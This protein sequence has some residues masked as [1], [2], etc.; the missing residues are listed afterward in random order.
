MDETRRSR[1][2][3]TCCNPAST[4]VSDEIVE[5]LQVGHAISRSHLPNTLH[6]T[7]ASKE[8]F[9]YRFKPIAYFE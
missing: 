8:V 6:A 1:R 3:F 4:E 5:I 9:E 2:D 7:I